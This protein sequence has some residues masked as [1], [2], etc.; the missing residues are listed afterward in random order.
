MHPPAFRL[1]RIDFYDGIVH[2]IRAQRYEE[3][4]ILKSSLKKIQRNKT[5]TNTMRSQMLTPTAHKIYTFIKNYLEKNPYAPN[6][7]EIAEGI[8][9][10]SRGAI[11]RYLKQLEEAKLIERTPGKHRNIRLVKKPKPSTSHLLHEPF[12]QPYLVNKKIAPAP[13]VI[14]NLIGKI[15]A[16]RPIEA[17]LDQEPMN[18]TDLFLK[19]DHY[20]LRVKGDSMIEEG[21][22]DG[23]IIVCQYAQHAHNGSIV[24]AILDGE[25]ATLKRYKY[26]PVTQIVTLFPANPDL[27]PIQYESHRVSIQG[28]YLGLLRLNSHPKG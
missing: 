13:S 18:L 10:T 11:P 2:I 8:G 15:A 6:T 17:I 14:I 1:A 23:D 21:I 3:K 9:I 20:A 16:G 24:V 22:F 19:D 7:Q 5:L 4:S 25:E 28:R 26:N 12:T 27:K